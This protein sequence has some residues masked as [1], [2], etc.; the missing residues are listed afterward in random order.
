MGGEI[1]VESE[2]NKGSTFHFHLPLHK[3]S[4]ASKDTE[5]PLNDNKRL[6]PAIDL[7]GKKIL[8][9]EDD[10]AN[11][12][13][14]ESYLKQAKSEILWARDGEQMLELF[15]SEPDLDLILLDLRMPNLNGID[16]IRIIRKA[17]K[18]IPVIA[19]TAYAFADDREKSL[20]AGCNDYLTKPVKVEQLSDTLSKYL[21]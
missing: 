8:I 21:T 15:R 18:D 17:N 10:S 4:K 3:N 1:W 16:A 6:K 13:F 2:E 9:A 11:Y 20:E 7:R 19:L 5:I 12:L 14:I